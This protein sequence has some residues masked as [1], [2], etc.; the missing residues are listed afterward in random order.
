[1]YVFVFS[2]PCLESI[3][4]YK[5]TSYVLLCSNAD[6]ATRGAREVQH[7]VCCQHFHCELFWRHVSHCATCTWCTGRKATAG[8][9]GRPRE[10]LH[11]GC[12]FPWEDTTTAH[13]PCSPVRTPNTWG[14]KIQGS[15]EWS[16]P[17]VC[18]NLGFGSQHS[19]QYSQRKTW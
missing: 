13:F 19:V 12:G 10:C 17:A 4:M 6:R 7:A 1:M 3:A 11:W 14:F 8:T 16:Q 18:G 5:F 9:T 2:H 15:R